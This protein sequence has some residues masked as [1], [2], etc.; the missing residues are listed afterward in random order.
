MG[1]H[2]APKVLSEEREKHFLCVQPLCVCVYKH[3]YVYAYNSKEE[4]R[5]KYENILLLGNSTL[6][7][8]W[9]INH[10]S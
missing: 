9:I 10:L 8:K 2:F 7:G 5:E 4:L 6:Q 3:M 1:G